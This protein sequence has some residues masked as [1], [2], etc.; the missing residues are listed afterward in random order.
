MSEPRVLAYHTRRRSRSTRYLI[1]AVAIL[2]AMGSGEWITRG[3][4]QPYLRRRNAQQMRQAELNALITLRAPR[5]T[6]VAVVVMDSLIQKNPKVMDAH[7]GMQGLY[8]TLT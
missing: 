7:G 3:V 4:I 6:P 1:I 5:S 2:I 8:T